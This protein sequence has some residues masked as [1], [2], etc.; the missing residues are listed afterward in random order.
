LHDLFVELVTDKPVNEIFQTDIN[1]FFDE[2]QKPPVRP[3]AKTF[4]DLSGLSAWLEK[5]HYER[6]NR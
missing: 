1:N 6:L 4:A 3:D 2:V 5:P